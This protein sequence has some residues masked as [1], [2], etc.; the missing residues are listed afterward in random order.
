MMKYTLGLIRQDT[1]VL[2]LNRENPPWMGSWNGVGGKLEDGESPKASMLREIREETGLD[3]PDAIFKGIITWSTPEG[4]GFG[5][6]YLYLAELSDVVCYPTPRRTVEGILD[7]KEAEWILHQ[8]NTGVAS[9]I[10]GCLEK[11][12]YDLGCY[13]YHS[14]YIGNRLIAQH[15]SKL[16]PMIEESER[17]REEYIAQYLETRGFQLE[18]AKQ[19]I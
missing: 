10:P 1:K 2:L 18:A 4:E 16:D 13:H 12:L 8:E 6:L 9:N 17:L 7:W 5:G 14:V 3:L 11:V 15:S 19:K